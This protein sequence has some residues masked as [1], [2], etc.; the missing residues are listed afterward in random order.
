VTP[1]SIERWVR[2]T[3]TA[4]KLSEQITVHTLRH[5]FAT[6]L[7]EQ[8]NDI[9]VIHDLLGHSHIQSTVR[10]AHVATK[11]ISRVQSPIEA[12]KF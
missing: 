1:R 7:L 6:H 12:I 5:S 3:V 10:Y 9:R 11:L 2:A 8:G 4:A